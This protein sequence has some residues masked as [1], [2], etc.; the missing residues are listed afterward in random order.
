MF[1]IELQIIVEYVSTTLINNIEG[2]RGC[3]GNKV[4]TWEIAQG[5]WPE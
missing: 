3:Q 2:T 5:P 1:V 4:K